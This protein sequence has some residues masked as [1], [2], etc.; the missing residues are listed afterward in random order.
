MVYVTHDGDN[1]CARFQ[2][3]FRIFFLYN[4]LRH[5][6]TD[7]FSLVTELFRHQIDGFSI[8]TLV[9]RHHDT[10]THTSSDD[11]RYGNVHHACQFVGG[12]EFRYLQ[13]F[14]VRHFAV[15]LLLHT[16]VCHIALVLTVF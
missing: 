10:D 15:F 12:Y 13:Y 16:A 7:V 8:Q 2:I 4:G 11:L 9:D 14:A 3:L 5:F 1:R 6:R